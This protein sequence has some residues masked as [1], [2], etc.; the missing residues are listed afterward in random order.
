MVETD[1]LILKSIGKCKGPKNNFGKKGGKKQE[2]SHYLPSTLT[3]RLQSQGQ[4][5]IT[6]EIAK[7][8][9]ETE[10]S[11]EI[12]PHVNGQLIFEQ[13]FGTNVPR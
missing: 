13:M 9:R 4:C 11:P 5:G 7:S 3:I 10:E 12:D 8:I 6:L 1:K 2:D